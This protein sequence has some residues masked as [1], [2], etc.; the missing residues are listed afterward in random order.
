MTDI[1]IDT[2]RTRNGLLQLKGKLMR[3]E[4]D[5]I[6]VRSFL[7]KMTS[8]KDIVESGDDVNALKEAF[9]A[10]SLLQH[11]QILRVLDEDDVIL[12]SHLRRSQNLGQDNLDFKWTP[13]CT[14]CTKTIGEALLVSKSE[15]SRFSSPMLSP[16][17]VQA[18]AENPPSA[19]QSLV[20]RMQSLELHFDDATF[21]LDHKMTELSP[22]FHEVFSNAESLQA[23]HFGFPSQ[24]PLTIRLDDI[25]QGIASGKLVAFGI[26]SWKLDADEIIAFVRR[27]REK[28]RGLRLRDVQ[29][30]ESSMWKDVLRV[31]REELRG[32]KWVSLRRIGYAKHFDELSSSPGIEIEDIPAGFSSSD[33]ES[34]DDERDPDADALSDE[35]DADT[36]F[37]A[38][39]EASSGQ[40]D[41]DDSGEDGPSANDM[42]FP[43]MSDDEPANCD[44]GDGASDL[45]DA[46]DFRDDGQY[47]SNGQR[48]L[49]EKWST[50]R[51]SI[52]NSKD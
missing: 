18:L 35:G 4:R 28:L 8:Q 10:F 22:L 12:L 51:C 46:E 17:S 7:Q 49:W 6:D 43:V 41:Y 44:C 30:K 26:Q 15:C 2:Q 9:C 45:S 48:K 40:E 33:E 3:R 47:V 42:G 11:V 24:R 25:F 5:A 37:S 23:V 13:A 31:L 29:L 27:H 32:L 50:R 39:S 19:L 16:N 20:K 34:V 36:D 14:H 38:D 1:R 52:H 21:D